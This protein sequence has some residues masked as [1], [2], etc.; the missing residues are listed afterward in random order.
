MI[1]TIAV[2]WCFLVHW[3]L[4]PSPRAR[5][6]RIAGRHEPALDERLLAQLADRRSRLPGQ[7]RTTRL[8]QLLIADLQ[9]GLIPELAFRNVIAPNCS[10]PSALLAAPPT[11]D[12]RVWRDVALVWSAAEQ[13]GFSMATALQRIHAYALVD[14]EIAGE[15]R[16]HAAAPRFAVAL[17]AL[18]PVAAWAV[19]GAG[20]QKPLD[21]LLSEPAGWVCAGSGIALFGAATFW[22]RRMTRA[23]LA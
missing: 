10:S 9:A 11:A 13:T 12:F 3:M 19:V 14:Q 1:S 21:W 20:G 23:A 4:P 2:A 7:P 18:M 6:L 22:I 16:A 8:L 5:L 17:L 15:V